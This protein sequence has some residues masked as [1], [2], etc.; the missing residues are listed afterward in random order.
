MDQPPHNPPTL[1]A[2][3]M[4]AWALSVI[5]A[6]GAIV[7]RGKFRVKA[8][9]EKVEA[10]SAPLI[11]RDYIANNAKLTEAW[12]EEVE[13]LRAQIDKVRQEGREELRLSREH[14]LEWMRRALTCESRVP[15]LEAEIKMLKDRVEELEKQVAEARGQR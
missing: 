3:G 5:A 6:L 13:K 15:S 10:E 7:V 9:K 8:L 11:E 1:S 2:E 14:E 12:Q 4:I